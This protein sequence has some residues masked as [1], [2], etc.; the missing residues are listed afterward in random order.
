MTSWRS[1]VDPGRE[2]IHVVPDD[3]MPHETN[4]DCWCGPDAAR[5]GS[6]TIVSHREE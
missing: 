6:L 5:E 4:L 3:A 2:S 1:I